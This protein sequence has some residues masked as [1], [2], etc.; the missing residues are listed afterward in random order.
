MD[1]PGRGFYFFCIQRGTS[2]GFKR[3]RM[4]GLYIRRITLVAVWRIERV[5]GRR[6]VIG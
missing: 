2:K 6:S 3:E 1:I 4:L 5:K